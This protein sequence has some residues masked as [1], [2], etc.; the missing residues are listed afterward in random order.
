MQTRS[1]T[2]MSTTSNSI[3]TNHHKSQ[4]TTAHI[5]V[6][7]SMVTRN[8]WGMHTPVKS[9]N[10]PMTPP[11][12]PVKALKRNKYEYLTKNSLYNADT[13]S[14]KTY[15]V[16]NL[17]QEFDAAFFDDA[18]AEWN[19]NKKKLGNGMYAYRTRSTTRK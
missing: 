11:P 2:P 13:T 10:R 17:N 9:N 8:R 14:E 18:S 16:S 12:T 4:P 7:R 5:M 15:P 3:S 19:K 1:Q 6:T